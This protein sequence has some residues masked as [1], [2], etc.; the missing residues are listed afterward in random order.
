MKKQSKKK[1]VSASPDAGPDIA[2]LILKV[3]Q[4]ISF[5]ERKIDTLISQ[6]QVKPFERKSGPESFQRFDPSRRPQEARQ[7]NN[8]RDRV[9]HKA[10]CA[11]C[12]KECEVP[13]KPSNDRPVY[14]KDCFSKRKVASPFKDRAD[15]RPREEARPHMSHI[16]RPHGVE[17][18]KFFG[19]RSPVAKRR[20]P[21][22]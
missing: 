7:G 5:L 15:N 8:Y 17:K 3:Q 14:C 13:F 12:N 2:E 6:S 20:K 11:D 9:L 10:I 4:Q 1:G 19:K 18:K 21:R 16:D 22:A